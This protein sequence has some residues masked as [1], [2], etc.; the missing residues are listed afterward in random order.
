[1]ATP[2]KYRNLYL[3][4]SNNLASVQFRMF[5]DSFRIQYHIISYPDPESTTACLNALST[6]FDDPANPGEK[7]AISGFPILIFDKIYW[8]APDLSD[9][10]AKRD[11]AFFES[12]L[13]QDFLAKTPKIV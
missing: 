11:C 1:M 8:E 3:Y 10:Y 12:Q 13:P 5:L 7:L 2:I 6:W 9:H 4:C